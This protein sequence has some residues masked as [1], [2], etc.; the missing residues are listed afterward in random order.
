MRSAVAASAGGGM[1]HEDMALAL[2]ISRNTLE[3]HFESEL[4]VGA[5]K[6]RMEVL[7]AMHRAAK[8][9]NVAAQK[10][11]MQLTPRTSAPPLAAAPVVPKPP[12]GKKEQAQADA[13]VAAVGTDW[14]DLLKRPSAPLQ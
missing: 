12:A 6:K 11:Y 10:A 9:G 14:E 5:F 4:S 13:Q 3:K 2:G 8:G 1:S 7:T